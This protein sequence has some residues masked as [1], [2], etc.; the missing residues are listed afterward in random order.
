MIYSDW[1]KVYNLESKSSEW[2][3]YRDSNWAVEY[4]RANW[5]SIYPECFFKF[6]DFRD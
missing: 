2:G 6:G 4:A 1:L 5:F 3:G